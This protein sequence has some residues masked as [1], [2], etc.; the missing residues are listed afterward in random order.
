MNTFVISPLTWLSSAQEITN[1][2]PINNEPNKLDIANNDANASDAIQQAQ[3]NRV[4][5]VQNVLS[6]FK[7]LGLD[8]SGMNIADI[9]NDK[10]IQTKF[11]ET[12]N[13]FVYNLYQLVSK[14]S[15]L[16]QLPT[17]NNAPQVEGFI[18]SNSAVMHEGQSISIISVISLFAQN[19]AESN[20]LINAIAN[21]G[22]T[23]QVVV[24]PGDVYATANAE[25]SQKKVGDNPF[26]ETTKTPTAVDLSS[27]VAD[28]NVVNTNTV[29]TDL[30]SEV[31]SPTTINSSPNQ[32]QPTDNEAAI[33][34]DAPV[35]PDLRE[36]ND[37][38]LK[39]IIDK[40]EYNDVNSN[41]QNLISM[42]NNNQEVAS[43][44]QSDFTALVEMVGGKNVSLQDFL[45]QM[46]S[47]T[48]NGSPQSNNLGAFFEAMV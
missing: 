2:N 47:N 14:R 18:L 21:N 23:I 38:V 12:V 25:A 26:N 30:P 8:V 45:K 6:S 33:N 3:D 41:L 35:S 48:Q 40:S 31:P 43:T 42:L 19:P 10:Q 4:A 1:A 39:Q 37:A 36:E 22:V 20:N 44:L 32:P 11:T 17:I 28:T 24:P 13:S 27:A 15:D 9:A 16:P 34:T 46:A 5:F 7:Q 29:N